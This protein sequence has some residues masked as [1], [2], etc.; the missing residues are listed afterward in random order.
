VRH[1]RRCVLQPSGPPVPVLLLRQIFFWRPLRWL[2]P[3]D[4]P[5]YEHSKRFRL[6]TFPTG[7]STGRP[8]GQSLL[9]DPR[10]Q[11]RWPGLE[12]QRDIHR[13]AHANTYSR[14]TDADTHGDRNHCTHTIADVYRYPFGYG[15]DR[16]NGNAFRFKSRLTHT[17]T[18]PAEPDT[19]SYAAKSNPHGHPRLPD[20]YSHSH[21]DAF[22]FESRV[23]IPNRYAA[24]PDADSYRHTPT[25]ALPDR[26]TGGD[27]HADTVTSTAAKHFHALARRNRE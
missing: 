19:H 3:V 13:D 9:S 6:R 20:A 7:R 8:R 23:T 27:T 16:T 2:D 12:G 21:G 11:P 4:G 18:H 1:C 10:R 26:N 15:H 25:D 22:A 17:L 5:G 14:D 24:K